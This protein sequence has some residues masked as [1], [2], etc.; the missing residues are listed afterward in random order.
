MFTDIASQRFLSCKQFELSLW[1]NRNWARVAW[2]DD[3]TRVAWVTT[4]TRVTGMMTLHGQG[5][6]GDGT[7][8]GYV[9]GAPYHFKPGT[10]N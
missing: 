3:W 2:G 1:Q 10:N 7:G 5:Y 8:Q 9:G 6:V 4:T